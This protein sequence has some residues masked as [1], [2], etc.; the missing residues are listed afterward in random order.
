MEISNIGTLPNIIQKPR[1]FPRLIM[2]SEVV[3]ISL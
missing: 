3:A 2:N 1:S